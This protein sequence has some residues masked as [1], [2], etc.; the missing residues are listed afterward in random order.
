MID[1]ISIIVLAGLIVFPIINS[2]ANSMVYVEFIIGIAFGINFNT[3][4]FEHT[5]DEEKYYKQYMFQFHLG[6]A[7]VTMSTIQ[8]KSLES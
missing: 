3:V 4:E 5:E 6:I 2:K 1:F 7:T 8:E